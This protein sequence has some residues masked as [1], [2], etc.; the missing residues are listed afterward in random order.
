MIRYVNAFCRSA[1][2]EAVKTLEE[3]N[4][5]YEIRNETGLVLFITADEFASLHLDNVSLFEFASKDGDG[6]DFVEESTD[7]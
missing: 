5:N 7:D 4:I 2:N 6:M 3:K 1:V